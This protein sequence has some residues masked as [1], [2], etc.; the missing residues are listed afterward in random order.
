MIRFID[1]P[2]KGVSLV[3]ENAPFLLRVVRAENGAWD[4]LDHASDEARPGESISVYRRI[5]VPQVAFVDFRDRGGGRR[6]QRLISCSYSHWPEPI[7][8]EDLDTSRAFFAW[9][10]KNITRILAEIDR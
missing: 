2:A 10:E 1:G 5:D 7:A 9:Y 6:G 3:L 8:A 4:A